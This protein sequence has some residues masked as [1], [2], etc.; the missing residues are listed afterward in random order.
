MA[1]LP[2]RSSLPRLPPLAFAPHPH[3]QA[4]R[5][6]VGRATG[7]ARGR[8]SSCRGDAAAPLVH[9]EAR[10]RVEGAPA[11]VAR[12]LSKLVYLRRALR[13]RS[14]PGA[15]VGAERARAVGAGALAR[16]FVRLALAPVA[17]PLAAV[18]VARV[19]AERAERLER[20]LAHLA[21][22]SAV[23][24][25]RRRPL[26]PTLPPIGAERAQRAAA[27]RP[28]PLAAAL[29]APHL[30][31]A[32]PPGARRR[33]SAGGRRARR[34]CR[35]RASTFRK[36]NGR[37]RRARAAPCGPRGSATRTR[38]RACAGRRGRGSCP[39]SRAPCTGTSCTA[40]CR[41]RSRACGRRAR[42][43]TR[44]CAGSAR[45]GSG[46]SRRSAA[47]PC[48]PRATVPSRS[49]TASTRRPAP[50]PC[51]S[52]RPWC[53]CT[54]RSASCRRRTACGGSRGRG[55]CRRASSTSRT[56]NGRRRSA[57]AAPSG[58]RASAPST[59]S[60]ASAPLPG[61]GLAV[62]VGVLALAPAASP[63]AA[64][65]EASV[66]AERRHR[67]ERPLAL[68]A[69]P[70][71]L[72]VLGGHALG[73]VAPPLAARAAERAR[74]VG[75]GR[76][77]AGLGLGARAPL[78]DHAALRPAQKRV[79]AYS[80]VRVSYRASHESHAHT[81]APSAATD[82]TAPTSSGTSTRV[83]AL[84]PRFLGVSDGGS[85]HAFSA[86]ARVRRN[87][88][89]DAARCGWPAGNHGRIRTAIGSVG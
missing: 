39:T 17:L 67:R 80:P 21:G 36:C 4:D 7:R 62:G 56:R 9:A 20:A 68:V 61:R 88:T 63:D 41:R 27:V 55:S 28:R 52:S 58:P 70:L 89:P 78:H 65:A 2:P 12:V 76:F 43:T 45:T 69:Q 23:G 48:A 73:A 71:A 53:N 29:V 40:S 34:C 85:G 42:G 25:R 18:A 35:T 64:V 30:A 50:A 83:R 77:V 49:S 33:R 38:R 74:A 13:A 11:R 79:C 47:A 81:H 37:S 32:A 10:H 15:A 5:R 6:C 22:V 1:H 46:R 3:P 75:A 87:R 66:A 86:R 84:V 19:H 51:R 24:V 54:T 8:G 14:P 60:R 31:P 44:T 16:R 57:A 26:V 82:A 72:V 59:R